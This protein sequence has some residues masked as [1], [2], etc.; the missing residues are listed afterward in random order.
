VAEEGADLC[1]TDANDLVGDIGGGGVEL[2][3]DGREPAALFGD[4]VFDVVDDD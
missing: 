2:T 3:E 4:V 1:G